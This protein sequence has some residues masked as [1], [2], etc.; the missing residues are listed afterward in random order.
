MIEQK[1]VVEDNSKGLQVKAD[2]KPSLRKIF[3]QRISKAHEVLP[4]GK[5]VAQIDF[6][7]YMWKK[8][9]FVLCLHLNFTCSSEKS[10]TEV[11]ISIV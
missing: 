6:M 10:L 11:L 5:K 4:Y 8:V 7:T 2:E 1:I 3:R 9:M